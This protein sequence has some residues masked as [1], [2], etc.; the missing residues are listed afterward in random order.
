ML[1]TLNVQVVTDPVTRMSKGFGFVRFGA[2]EEADQALQTM[3]G[4]YCS[5][6]PMRVSVATDRNAGRPRVEV[7]IQQAFNAM[8]FESGNSTVFIGGLEATITEE[9]LRSRF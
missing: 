8:D 6:R 2:R 4:V 5:S 3:N 7:G 1:S 9:E